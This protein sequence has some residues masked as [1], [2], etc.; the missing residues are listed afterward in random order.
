MTDL[1][2]L[3]PRMDA[4]DSGNSPYEDSN[5]KLS[6]STKGQKC[7]SLMSKMANLNTKSAMKLPTKSN[8]KLN[9]LINDAAD[10]EDTEVNPLSHRM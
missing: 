3:T 7:S 8:S 1:G 6:K 2:E 10:G 4:D 5:T 9:M